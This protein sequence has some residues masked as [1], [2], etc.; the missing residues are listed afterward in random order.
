VLQWTGSA[1]VLGGVATFSAG[2]A[3][4]TTRMTRAT[5]SRDA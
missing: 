3:A 2:R 1:L 4:I 5:P